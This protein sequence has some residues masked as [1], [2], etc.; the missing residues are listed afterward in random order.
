M[1]LNS[2]MNG[3]PMPDE[4][5]LYN[6][7]NFAVGG[8]ETSSYSAT[9]GVE[10]LIEYPGQYEA[11]LDRPELL[12][13]AVEEVLRW[14]STA[15]YVQRVA[16]RDLEM[17]GAQIRAGDAV[18]LWNVS[19]NRDEGQFPEP[20]KFDVE[21]SP[22]RH[23]TFGGGI[24]RCIGAS[25]GLVELGEVFKRLVE[26]RIRLRISGEVRRLRS[27]FILGTTSLPVEIAA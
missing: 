26:G 8:D 19:A 6:C 22:N 1:L 13:S 17:R 15:S 10:A 2:N 27:N 21:R 16:T 25:V 11:L 23:V 18:T 14:S 7:M 20:M 4:E 12:P 9:S 24:H 3:K 5:I